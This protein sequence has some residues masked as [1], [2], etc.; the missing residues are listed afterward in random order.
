V[1]ALDVKNSALCEHVVEY[2]YEIDWD[3]ACIKIGSKFSQTSY[4]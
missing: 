4:E 3:N 2:D 1:R